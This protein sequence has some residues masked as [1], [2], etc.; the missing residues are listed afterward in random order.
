MGKQAV[1][2]GGTS[3]LDNIQIRMNVMRIPEVSMRLR[4]A[5][6]AI[7]AIFKQGL[8]LQSYLS[9]DDSVFLRN[10][11]LKTLCTAIV[12]IGLFDRLKKSGFEA[13]LFVGL[14]SADS[15]IRVITGKSTLAK[16][17]AESPAL[18]PPSQATLALIPAPVLSSLGLAEIEVV[19]DGG[20]VLSSDVS[21][22]K[23]K[24]HQL[25]NYQGV[26]R[27]MNIGPIPLLSLAEQEA[28]KAGVVVEESIESDPMLNWFWANASQA[29]AV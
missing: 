6:T 17:I 9:S 15:A 18:Q 12:Q 10:Q 29:A 14:K 5:Q 2:F 26:D 1:V 7:D 25:V 21:D 11:N 24:L 3:S 19:A 22:A 4:E 20:Q 8:H 13:Q 27:L 23:F 28:L 16:L